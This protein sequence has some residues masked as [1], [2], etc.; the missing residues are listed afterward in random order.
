MRQPETRQLQ[1]SASSTQDHPGHPLFIFRSERQYAR[2]LNSRV[3]VVKEQLHRLLQLLILEGN[4]R[5]GC[6]K[7]AMQPIC[8]SI[9]FSIFFSGTIPISLFFPSLYMDL[10]S[11]FVCFA[12]LL[13]RSVF[14]YPMF[15]ESSCLRKV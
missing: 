7:P 1:A 15:Y 12:P 3:L 11:H 6:R 5:K 8:F 2:V 4:P 9:C 14:K 13:T 10:L